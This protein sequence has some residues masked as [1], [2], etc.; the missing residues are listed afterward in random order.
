MGVDSL[1]PELESGMAEDADVS[2]AAEMVAFE[3]MNK[4]QK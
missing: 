4:A 3:Q 1:D 2:L